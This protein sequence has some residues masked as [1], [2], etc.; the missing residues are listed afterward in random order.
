M[1]IEDYHN[2]ALATT[3]TFEQRKAVVVHN[4]IIMTLTQSHRRV[5]SFIPLFM[6]RD[7]LLYYY[8]IDEVKRSRPSLSGEICS[9]KP[10]IVVLMV[11]WFCGLCFSSS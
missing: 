7:C 6:I 1:S 9:Q 2:K 3:I 4:N 11:D 8:V 5:I 10:K